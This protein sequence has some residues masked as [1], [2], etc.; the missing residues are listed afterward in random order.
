M[1]FPT[2]AAGYSSYKNLPALAGLCT[3]EEAAKPGLLVE[4]CVRRLK[5]FH[6]CFKRLHQILTARITAEPIYEL[7]TAFAH[8]A[9]LCAEHVS[10]LRTRIAEMREPPLGLEDVPHPALEGYFDEILNAPGTK[11]LL[12]GVYGHA[13]GALH[14]D[15][16]K[17][18]SETNPLTDA[19]SRRVL[20]FA[21]LEIDEMQQFGMACTAALGVT[22]NLHEW[23]TTVLD[24]LLIAADVLGGPGVAPARHGEAIPRLYSVKPYVYDPLPKRDERFSDP[25]NQG[26]NAES[27]LYNPAYPARA[28]ALMM[29]YK[30]LREIDVPE[31]MASI[32]TR[33]P[34]KPWGY[35]RDMSRQLW[36]E[37]RHA[38]M[39][40]VGFVAL[41]VD[42]TKVKITLN[43]SHRLNTECTPL[44]A[45]GVLYFI[46]Q[47]LMPKTGKRYEF[48]VGQESGLPLIA[49]LQDFD[50]ADEV[51][52]SQ[53]GRQWYV[54]L[55][56][57]LK[58]SLDFGDAA[59]SR[60]LSNWSA[61]KEQGLTNHENWWP[62][63]YEMACAS[64]G[65][66]PDAA[67]LAFAETYEG[68]RADLKDVAEGL[69][70]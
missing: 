5:R 52:H 18:M 40:E 23:F 56:G 45:H 68:K 59:W 41:G 28:K 15:I 70:G 21:A 43:W 20:R 67:V 22:P 26:V 39:G 61:V 11:E 10:A 62:A 48:E 1:S 33:T 42:W 17:Y 49:T 32:I 63:V 13:L 44:E 69:S 6:Y 58:E 53:I 29:L 47:G 38:M 37:A 36:D 57:S 3:I 9:Y 54:P 30:R 14:V 34:G 19:P 65:V 35:Y 46:E 31:M 16:K 66:P 2:P 64:E 7:K 4:E 55:F 27:F 60:I 50:W 51:L 24:H 25:W 12:A 8:H